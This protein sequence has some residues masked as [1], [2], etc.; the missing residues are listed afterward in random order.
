MIALS[1]ACDRGADELSTVTALERLI[2]VV[3]GWVGLVFDVMAGDAASTIAS[4]VF[5]VEVVCFV[6]PRASWH[7]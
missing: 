6:I 4:D 7:A 1:P 5:R 3:A 2:G